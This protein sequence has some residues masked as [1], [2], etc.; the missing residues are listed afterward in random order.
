[1]NCPKC[2]SPLTRN[3][4]VTAKGDFSFCLYC[5]ALLVFDSPG[6]LRCAVRD[7]IENLTP[8]E[9][10]DLGKA[11]GMVLKGLKREVE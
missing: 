6:T 1:M 7:D 9:A 11:R 10:F 5:G 3:E 2:N 4:N 8:E